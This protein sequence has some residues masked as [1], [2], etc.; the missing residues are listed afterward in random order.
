MQKNI[1]T[2]ERG[3][4]EKQLMIVVSIFPAGMYNV[5][6]CPAGTCMMP[7]LHS[8]VTLNLFVACGLLLHA[9]GAHRLDFGMKGIL[10]SLL[11][12]SFLESSLAR[13]HV[14]SKA[15]LVKKGLYLWGAEGAEPR[16]LPSQA[17]LGIPV[18][19]R[20]RLRIGKMMERVT[21]VCRLLMQQCSASFSGYRY[22]A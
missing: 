15:P 7:I 3:E 8:S 2:R 14:W 18:P 19:P 1:K 13:G 11:Q 22:A 12:P 6:G 21:P 17:D 20:R 16:K 9:E 4:R 5:C 10:H